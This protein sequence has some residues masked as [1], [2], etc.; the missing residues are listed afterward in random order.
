MRRLISILK[1][2]IE[3]LKTVL[4]SDVRLGNCMEKYEKSLFFT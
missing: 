3:E 4:I 1:P 2:D